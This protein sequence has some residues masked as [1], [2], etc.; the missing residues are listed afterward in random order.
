[1][2]KI[3]NQL[4]K[5][6]SFVQPGVL[7]T[8]LCKNSNTFILKSL[9]HLAADVALM[10]ILAYYVRD[11]GFD[12]RTVQTFVCINMSACIVPGYFYA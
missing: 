5:F 11:Y 8:V 2:N 12:S 7:L 10:G 9:Q 1:V 6:D 3:K 4:E